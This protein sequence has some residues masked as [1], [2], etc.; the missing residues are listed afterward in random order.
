[1]FGAPFASDAFAVFAGAVVEPTEAFPVFRVEEALGKFS[2]FLAFGA[3]PDERC[4]SISFAAPV[5]ALVGFA[6]D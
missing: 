5:D 4:C 3:D 1:M 2:V 6:T